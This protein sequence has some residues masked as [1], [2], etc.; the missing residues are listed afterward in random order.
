MSRYRFLAVEDSTGNKMA[1]IVEA[2]NVSGA[3]R[4]MK[5]HDL[6]PGKVEVVITP[7]ENLFPDADG[8]QTRNENRFLYVAPVENPDGTPNTSLL[9]QL[10]TNNKEVSEWINTKTSLLTLLGAWAVAIV[11]VATLLSGIG[12]ALY[13]P[14]WAVQIIRDGHYRSSS[15]VSFWFEVSFFVA[16]S[17]IIWLVL[18]RFFTHIFFPFFFSFTNSKPTV[19]KSSEKSRRLPP[20][21]GRRYR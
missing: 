14:Y 9:T 3:I 17:V 6:Q 1:G 10:G 11:C 2:V 19:T 4:L 20:E 16:G 12:L 8:Q 13:V 15:P 7:D 5:D 18:I 21:S